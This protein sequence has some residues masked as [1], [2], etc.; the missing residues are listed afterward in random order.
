VSKINITEFLN[1][2]L[3]LSGGKDFATGSYKVRFPPGVTRATF[4]V[5]IIDDDTI[6]G[7]E[8]F[9]LSIDSSSLPNRISLLPN[10]T[11]TVKLIDDDDHKCKLTCVEIFGACYK[12]II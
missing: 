1:L 11:L 9:Y 2:L 12:K 4:N 6:E 5:M 10:C 3:Q 8:T 7:T